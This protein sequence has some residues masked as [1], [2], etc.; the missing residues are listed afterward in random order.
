[1]SV[2]AVTVVV[3]FRNA[4]EL[5]PALLRGLASQR[6]AS[7][8]EAEFVFVDN[9]STDGGAQ[10]IRDFGLANSSVVLEQTRGVSAARNRGLATA[11]GDVIAIV[12]SD[13]IPSRQ[14]LRELVEPFADAATHICAGSLA[15]YP[16]RTGA[17]RFAARYGMNDGR[18]TLEMELPFANGRNMAVRRTSACAVGGWAEDLLQ[19]DDI[20]F[21]TR[22]VDRFGCPIEYREHALVYHRDRES[23]EELWT[24]A[25]AY[26]RGVA[27]VY[28]RYPERLPWGVPQRL[29][30]TRMAARRRLRS[31]TVGV[32]MRFGLVTAEDAEFAR[33]L[34][35]WDR[36]FWRGFHAERRRLRLTG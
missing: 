16:P 35:A 7:L 22:L 21:S 26:G 33:Y 20:D 17:Q 11:R 1:V 4:E 29:A 2:P 30:R 3:P 14:W 6:P 23:D 18:R 9:A 28:E 15:S 19:G 25:E 5:L 34:Q 31:A 8:G 36:R 27:A 10:L 12:D 32:G 24:Q 13:C